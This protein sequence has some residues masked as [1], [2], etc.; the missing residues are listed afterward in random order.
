VVK[1][2]FAPQLSVDERGGRTNQIS[3]WIANLPYDR[4]MERLWKDLTDGSISDKSYRV[5]GLR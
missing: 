5:S 1:P 3:P 2:F 4:R